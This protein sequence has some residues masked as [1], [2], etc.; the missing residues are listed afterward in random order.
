[1]RSKCK[2]DQGKRQRDRRA[3]GDQVD[4]RDRIGVRAAEIQAEQPAGPMEVADEK[5]LI[6]AHLDAQG[7]HGILGGVE[8]EHR[9]RRIAGEDFEHRE[10][11]RRCHGQG[12]QP[13]SERRRI[14]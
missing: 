8:A 6:E 1:M 14:R 9:P 7:L 10:N 4:D 3:L 2:R 5:A 13:G 11:R 12:Q